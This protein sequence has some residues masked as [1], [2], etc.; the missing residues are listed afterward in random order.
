VSEHIR[1]VSGRART[2]RFSGHGAMLGGPGKPTSG[3]GVQDPEARTPDHLSYV[4]DDGPGITRRRAGKGFSYRY[5]DGAKVEDPDTLK[6]IRMLGIPPAW[7]NVWICIDPNGHIQATGR[8]LR[9]RKQY[10]YHAGWTAFRDEAKFGSLIDFAY[11]LPKLRERVDAD[12]RRRGLPRE[13]VIASVIWLLD[14]T[15]IRIGNET[16]MRENKSY[17]LTTLRSKHVEIQ[18]SS[19]RFSFRGKSGKEWRLKLSDRRIAKIVRAIQE[20]PGQHLF[21]YLDEEGVRREI[22]SQNVNEYIREAIGP[23]FTSKHF[24]T[25]NATVYAALE[26]SERPLPPTKRAQTLTLNEVLDRVSARLNNTR[27]V[28]RSCYVHPAIFETWLDG[29]FEKQMRMIRSRI[30][31]PLENLEPEEYA[32]LRWLERLAAERASRPTLKE[33]LQA[34]VQEQ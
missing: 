13:R 27:A 4:N 19:L 30:R 21:Q 33:A 14:N 18:G 25:W 7:T 9:G 28:C 5:P 31:K 3:E 8:D 15:L 17:G 12:L 26:L 24:R 2:M 1:Q 16:Y 22:T 20:L 34:S 29:E 6:R 32:V 11:S 10:R 23:N